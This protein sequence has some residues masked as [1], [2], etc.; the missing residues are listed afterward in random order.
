M[1]GSPHG[2]AQTPPRVRA[3]LQEVE[4]RAGIVGIFPNEGFIIRLIGAVLLEASDERQTRSRTMQTG[5]SAELRPPMRDVVAQ[6]DHPT[7]A[8]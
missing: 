6:P 7:Q 5:A 4:R 3:E 2:S 8:A 1:A